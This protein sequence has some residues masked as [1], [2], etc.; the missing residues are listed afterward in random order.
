MTDKQKISKIEKNLPLHWKI[1]H[2]RYWSWPISW[3]LIP[4]FPNLCVYQV[5]GKT[6]R[7]C[8]DLPSSALFEAS[9]QIPKGGAPLFVPASQWSGSELSQRQEVTFSEFRMAFPFVKIRNFH[10][11]VAVLILECNKSWRVK[12][13]KSD[14]LT[15]KDTKRPI[16]FKHKTSE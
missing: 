12:R 10:V 1:W 7:L 4:I 14:G 8:L 15:S 16:G 6:N 2:W 13:C 5:C 3:R 11:G 9:G